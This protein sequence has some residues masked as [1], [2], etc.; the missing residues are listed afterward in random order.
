M[1]PNSGNIL[2]VAAGA[3]VLLWAINKHFSAINKQ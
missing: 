1:K 2:L 3:L